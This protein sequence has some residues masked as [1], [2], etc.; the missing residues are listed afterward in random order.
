MY[1]QINLY[2]PIFR[3]EHHLLSALTMVQAAVMLLS[4]LLVIYGYASWQV[5]GVE[6]ELQQL[7]NR[8]KAYAAQVQR[9]GLSTDSGQRER[10]EAELEVVNRDLAHQQEL[11]SILEKQEFGGAAGF[12]PRMTALARSH[13]QGLWL[14]RVAL[15]GSGGEL[16]IAGESLHAGLIP[17]YLQRLSEQPALEG[18]QFASLEMARIPDSERVRFS[19]SSRLLLDQEGVNQY[20]RAT[21]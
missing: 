16:Q 11:V 10:V 12:S 4:A 7:E 21:Q 8:E 1:Q 19:V 13:V 14:T 2:Q 20:A 15:S 5:L 9:L 17:E 6:A 18:V 3:K